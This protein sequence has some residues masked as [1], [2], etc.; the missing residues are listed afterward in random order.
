[1]DP[2]ATLNDE[3][4]S[5]RTPLALPPTDSL[6]FYAPINHIS[7]I[8]IGRKHKSH[9]QQQQQGRPWRDTEKGRGKGKDKHK[10]KGRDRKMGQEQSIVDENTPTETLDSRTVEAV[11]KYIKDGHAQRIVVMVSPPSRQSSIHA[12]PTPT[13]QVQVL[14]HLPVFQTSDRLR[15]DSTPTS[16]D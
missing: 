3:L 9:R 11:G 16:S 8:K 15:L 6:P 2:G 5:I 1:M 10:D 13:R 14:A 12:I 7:P 4:G